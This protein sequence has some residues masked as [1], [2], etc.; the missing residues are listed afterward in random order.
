[1]RL[2]IFF[3][4]FFHLTIVVANYATGAPQ[5]NKSTTTTT[6]T[7]NGIST[8]TMKTDG[9]VTLIDPGLDARQEIANYN[10][11][12]DEI[13]LR[14]NAAIKAKDLDPMD[15][16]LLP[17]TKSS[18]SKVPRL[19]RTLIDSITD[20]IISQD[21]KM[22]LGRVKGWLYGMSTLQ[23]SSDV[24]IFIHED[25][26]TI[27][28]PF[29]LGPLELRVAKTIGDGEDVK[30]KS[31][32][33]T[34]ELMLGLMDMKIDRASGKAEIVNVNFDEPGG[35]DIHGNLK[36]RAENKPDARPYRLVMASKAA[37]SL[38]K[39][40]RLIVTETAKSGNNN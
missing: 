31:A 28:C 8:T 13:F 27:Q 16:K 19:A 24:S 40:A 34:T 5:E 2:K 33:A 22:N 29:A 21:R 35:V 32:R 37:Q 26:R 1:M 12:M 15:L 39:I 20:N 9:G 3:K 18:S 23:R 7:T 30:T 38:K 4:C 36:R 6:T 11:F 10:R 17:N 14:M 25:H